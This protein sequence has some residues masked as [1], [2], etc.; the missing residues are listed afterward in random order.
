M[1]M[2]VTI[3]LVLPRSL[4]VYIAVEYQLFIDRHDLFEKKEHLNM[5]LLLFFPLNLHEI[6]TAQRAK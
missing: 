3:F 2:L 1:I 4:S 5:F 6:H